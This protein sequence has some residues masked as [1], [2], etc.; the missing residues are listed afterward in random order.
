MNLQ[1]KD[2]TT[3]LIEQVQDSAIN[4]IQP[5][6]ER[7]MVLAAEYA[8]ACG[9]DIVLGEDM[10]SAM[11]YC[12]M[13][14]VGKKTGTYFPEIYDESDSEEEELDVVFVLDALDILIQYFL[15]MYCC[16]I[17]LF[18]IFKF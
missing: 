8:K 2:A 10:E 18:I 5:I 9:R 11:K 4:I 15:S 14:E 17:N 7:S 3:R 1:E 6:L 12:A 16:L 13:N